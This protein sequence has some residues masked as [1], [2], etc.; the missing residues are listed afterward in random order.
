MCIL[1]KLQSLKKKGCVLKMKSSHV[2]CEVFVVNYEEFH[3]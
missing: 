3:I 2:S 1:S